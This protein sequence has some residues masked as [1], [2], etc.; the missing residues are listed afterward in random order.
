MI[1]FTTRKMMTPL[2]MVAWIRIGVAQRV[3]EGNMDEAVRC[4][5]WGGMPWQI[6]RSELYRENMYGVCFL[7]QS[8]CDAS[9]QESRSLRDS[10]K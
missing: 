4:I 6:R 10:G 1:R 7:Y 9:V 5:R 3:S 8:D 2:R